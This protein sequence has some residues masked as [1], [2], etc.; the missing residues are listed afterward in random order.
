MSTTAPHD[1][2]TIDVDHH[3]SHFREHNYEIYEQLRQRCP[4]AHSNA[5]GGFWL[6]VNY[7]DIYAAEQDTETFS[8]APAK[9][10]PSAGTPDPFVPIDTDP[11]LLQEYRK[12]T[13]PWF[14]PTAAKRAEADIRRLATELIDE[15]IEGGQAD[16]VG[17][18][19]TPLPAIWILRLLGFDDTHWADWVDWI[20][21][22]VHDRSSDTEKAAAG[23]ANIY[24]SIIAEVQ[25]RRTDGFGDDLL[26]VIMQGLVNGEPLRDE[27]V[28]G[29]AFMM[30]LG[31]MDTTSGLT[32][33]AL[34]Q[35]DRHPEL[36]AR[37]IREPEIL[38]RATEEFLRHDTPVQG[39]ARVV[40]TD[41]EFR[42]QQL[43]AGDRV[44]LMLAAA[45]RDPEA[46]DDPTRLDFDRSPNRHLAFGVGPHRCLGSNFARVMFQV[47]ISEILTRLPDYSICG[48]VARFADAGDVYAVRSLPIRFT[49]GTRLSPR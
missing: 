15:F 47:M 23:V 9:Q 27:Q 7:D 10:I 3:S 6:L 38:P 26:S 17:Q 2:L 48:E 32:G 49:P 30:L 31:G 12:I 39:E 8:S 33:N 43:R 14:S 40:T 46:F 44:M 21:A 28:I 22:V 34:V 19:T 11:P 35:L 37:L 45:N 18:F 13:L 4:V 29:Y 42:G 1:D 16:I 25:R 36:R 41:C 24:S 20:H 5:W